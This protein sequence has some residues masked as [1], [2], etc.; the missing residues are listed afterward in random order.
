MVIETQLSQLR[1]VGI[2]PMISQPFFSSKH[3]IV[4]WYLKETI[5]EILIPAFITLKKL[6]FCLYIK[7]F[8]NLSYFVNLCF[9][10]RAQEHSSLKQVNE[11]LN[12]I[13]YTST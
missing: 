9:A 13:K 3:S 1:L 6:S 11:K 5:Y 7:K 12:I 4:S 10:A 8:T 2:S